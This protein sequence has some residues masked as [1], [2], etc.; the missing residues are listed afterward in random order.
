MCKSKLIAFAV[1]L[2]FS[3]SEMNLSIELTTK[4]YKAPVLISQK[5]NPVLQLNLKLD[6]T[7]DSAVV[8]FVTIDLDGTDNLADIKTIRIWFAGSDSVLSLNTDFRLFSETNK[9]A[10]E[11]TLN[12][13]QPLDKGDNFFWVSIELNENANL[14]NKIGVALSKVEFSDNTYLK[15]NP[16]ASKIIQRIGVAVRKHMDDKV[17]TYRI[18][19]IAK[20]NEATCRKNSTG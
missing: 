7:A 3:C 11:I 6:S 5:E 18:P 4:N 9:S 1:I 2:L 17:H 15:P 20:K 12:G 19:G 8:E 14:H 16:E 13:M 10:K